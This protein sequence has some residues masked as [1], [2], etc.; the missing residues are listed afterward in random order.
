MKILNLLNPQAWLGQ[1]LVILSFVFF[2][3]IIGMY[4]APPK[5]TTK[6]SIEMNQRIKA[7]GK[8]S[9]TSGGLGQP[10]DCDCDDY[11]RGLTRKEIRDILKE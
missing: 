11:I 2:G 7:K 3:G 4:I 1:I 9:V 5:T 8:G 6:T 10:L